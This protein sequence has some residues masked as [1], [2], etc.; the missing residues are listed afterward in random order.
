VFSLLFS[1]CNDYLVNLAIK[2]L[3]LF[4]LVQ[5]WMEASKMQIGQIA[6]GASRGEGGKRD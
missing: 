4:K 5:G 2:S 3:Q 6:V 1:P